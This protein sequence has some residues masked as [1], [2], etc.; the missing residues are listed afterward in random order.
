[1]AT[2]MLRTNILKH[3]SMSS[4]LFVAFLYCLIPF[5]AGASN[6]A[7]VLRLGVATCLVL[8]VLLRFRPEITKTA[9]AYLGLLF[10]FSTMA[11]LR[12]L[13]GGVLALACSAAF[14]VLIASAAIQSTAFR[15]TLRTSLLLLI[16][17]S[18]L[19]LLLQVVVYIYNGSVLDIHQLLYPVSE[20][21]IYQNVGF[22]R[23]TGF[24]IEPGTYSNW[25][26]M[27]LMIYV[28]ISPGR[29]TQLVLVVAAS[30]I[31]TLSAWGGGVAALLI[32]VTA[33]SSGKWRW[34]VLVFT[35]LVIVIIVVPADLI[36][37][38]FAVYEQ[39]TDLDQISAGSKVETYAEFYRILDSVLVVGDGFKSSFCDFCLSPQDAG[40]ALNISVVLGLLFAVGMF[41]AYFFLLLRAGEFA[42][43]TL[44]IPFLFTKAFYWDFVV[45]LLFFL[46]VFGC[47]RVVRC[48]DSKSLRG[49]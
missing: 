5:E 26:Y 1:M 38:W 39:K 42:F 19:T 6:F 14:G 28:A 29:S 16:A 37:G 25:L 24:Y 15:E 48:R 36:D 33:L 44:S 34:A 49:R 7:I 40:L 2:N 20:A 31:F 27:L 18:V 32:I 4:F 30:M 41:G 11:A 17:F 12:G 23:L 46:V 3:G 47:P 13:S 22:M 43:A 21:R 9:A 8:L 45:W 35:V 10:V